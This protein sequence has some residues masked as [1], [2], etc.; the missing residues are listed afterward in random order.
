MDE[1]TAVRDLR[2][3]APVPDHARLTPARR[4]LLDEIAGPRRRRPGWR[5]AAV[6]AAAAVTA[7]AVLTTLLGS[8][9]KD[10][11]MPAVD[12]RP[13]QWIYEK[14]FVKDRYGVAKPDV[15][16][17]SW[18]GGSGPGDW[19][20]KGEY[21]YG[22]GSRKI[23]FS[24][25]GQKQLK[26]WEWTPESGARTPAAKQALLARLP[27]DPDEV[28]TMLRK[29]LND[30]RAVYPTQAVGDISRVQQLLQ[31][32]L[33][34][35][36]ARAALYRALVG[37]PG[38]EVAE[39]QVKDAVGRPAVAVTYMNGN[40]TSRSGG[41]EWPISRTEIL[42]DPK[43]YAYLG[44]RQVYVAGSARHLGDVTREGDVKRFTEDTV[45]VD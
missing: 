17:F 39:H 10:E 18:H 30:P 37:I 38:V 32:P 28:L 2:A 12:P 13:D 5:L 36:R 43:T 42:L 44:L 35:P 22:Y 31:F 33:A 1:M 34:A 20:K 19:D 21:W 25:N 4:R 6:G 7:A 9:G 27:D 40:P 24:Y 15:S 29:E 26:P 3:D 45:Y 8:G 41:R 14:I 16:G 23:Y 11:S